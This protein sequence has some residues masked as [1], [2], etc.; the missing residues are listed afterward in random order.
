MSVSPGRIAS[1]RARLSRIRLLF[2]LA[3]ALYMQI[4]KRPLSLSLSLSAFTYPPPP[5]PLAYV[6]KCVLSGRVFTRRGC[7]FR[8]LFINSDFDTPALWHR[9]KNWRVNPP[10]IVSAYGR[11]ISRSSR[12][13]LK[14]I[15]LRFKERKRIEEKSHRESSIAISYN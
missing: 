4:R 11:R 9:V 10:F 2:P 8:R 13:R 15:L 3:N 6:W 1:P 12:V 14:F 7:W 5:P